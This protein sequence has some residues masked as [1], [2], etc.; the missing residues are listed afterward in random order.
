MDIQSIISLGLFVVFLLFITFIGFPI[1]FFLFRKSIDRGFA[2]TKISIIITLSFTSWVIGH[3]GP[4]YTFPAIFAIF[5]SIAGIS[6]IIYQQEKH[7][8]YTFLTNHKK[9]LIFEET[10]FWAFFTLLLIIRIG[11]PD[12]W[13]PAMG[14]EK[15]MDF[16]FINAIIRATSLPPFDPWFGDTTINYYYFGQ[17]MTATI[18]KLLSVP[19]AIFYNLFLAFIF[20]QSSVGIASIVFSFTKSKIFSMLGSILLLISG[21]LAQ[22]PVIVQSLKASMPING[23][24]W[25]ATRV[26]PNFEIN[27]FPFFSFLYADLHSHLV[28]LPVSLL[29]IALLM[30]I[31][32]LIISKAVKSVIIISVVT[33]F[34]MG[35]LRITNIWD[36]P[37][38][39]L[40]SFLVITLTVLFGFKTGILKRLALLCLISLIILAGS[41]LSVLPFIISY[42]T[43]ALGI[44]IYEGASTRIFDYLLINGLFLSFLAP[45]VLVIKPWHSPDSSRIIRMLAYIML[46]VVALFLAGTFKFLVFL[47]LLIILILL[48]LI[49]NRKQYLLPGA[50]FFI[51]AL[52]LTAIPDIVDIKLGLGRMNTVFKFYFQAWIFFSIGSA[53]VSYY[54]F[55]YT[56]KSKIVRAILV[57]IFLI[58]IA[59]TLL[60][61]LTAT[62]AKIADRM[63]KGKMPTL[64]G[65]YYMQSSVYH[66]QGKELVLVYDLEAIEWIN[67][68]V[69]D[70][71]IILEASTPIYRWGSRISV[72]TGLPTVLG[73]D[74]HEI[75]HRQYMNPQKIQIRAADTRQM[76]E[77]SEFETTKKLFLRYNVSY[78]YLGQLERAYYNTTGI[79]QLVA[80]HPEFFKYV[81]T[82][83]EVVI[84]KFLNG[85]SD[86]NKKENI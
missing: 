74:W 71:P 59:A 44:G 85:Q 42:K 29:V 23:W 19:S 81:Y 62:P 2:F 84:Y 7:N 64:N 82:N 20:A 21:N 26:M 63:G 1:S 83:P 60:Y 12:L 43:G 67:T 58:I 57:S 15:P 48:A 10:V 78:I 79:E 22:I 54:I 37:T 3:I 27:E 13:H 49:I 61:P 46:A 50:G 47:A 9:L 52:F 69:K 18:S 56:T 32:Q 16:A 31:C 33:A 73:W 25:T 40:F 55:Q 53:I 4:Y 68:F 11:N 45:F 39:L 80:E 34:I 14:G 86:Q 51:F 35:I 6:G 65:T 75:A 66:D 77:S 24:Y 17:F 5:V 76:Y 36:Y 72:Y 70:A 28:A 30:E 8:I 38:F 41:N